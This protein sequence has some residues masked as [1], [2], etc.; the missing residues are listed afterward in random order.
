MGGL[1][2]KTRPLATPL[3][4]RLKAIDSTKAPPR[5]WSSGRM[6]TL[7]S[8]L[9]FASFPRPWLLYFFLIWS[10]LFEK[11]WKSWKRLCVVSGA[12]CEWMICSSTML[13]LELWQRIPVVVSERIS[14]RLYLGLQMAVS[15]RY[16][17]WPKNDGGGYNLTMQ[18]MNYLIQWN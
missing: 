8:F 6:R 5:L 17:G 1:T 10:Q 2:P 9:G 18:R 11:F 16:T 14:E 3:T 7:T 12:P 13:I 15:I 4:I